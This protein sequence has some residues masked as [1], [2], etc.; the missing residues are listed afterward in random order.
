MNFKILNSAK[1]FF[2]ENKTQHQTIFKNAAWLMA[3]EL[4]VKIIS[5]FALIWLARYLGPNNYGKIAFATNFVAIF[6]F[7]VDFGF[8]T[9]A[10][11]E[12]AKDKSKIPQYIDNILFLQIILGILTF[13]LIFIS[14]IFVSNDKEVLYL[15]YLLGFSGIL[16]IFI[17]F[18]QS[19]F[20]ATEKMEYT[21]LSKVIQ[22]VVLSFIIIFLILQKSSVL[23]IGYAYLVSSLLSIIITVALIWKKITKFFLK[24]DLNFCKKI[25]IEAWPLAILY[26]TLLIFQ[27]FDSIIIGFTRSNEEV[28]LYGAGLRIILSTSLLLSILYSVFLPPISNAFHNKAEGLKSIVEKYAFL[29][30]GLGL[31]LSI[32]GFIVAP[33]LVYFLYGKQYM[34][35]I[36]PFQILSLGLIFVFMVNYYGYCLIF[37]NKQKEV[38]KANLIGVIINV[39]LDLIVI[40]NCGIIGAAVVSIITQLCIL[41]FLFINFEKIIKIN[42]KYVMLPAIFSSFFMA[43]ILFLIK[44]KFDFNVLVLIF[45]GILVYF[46]ACYIF[47][48]Y[49]KKAIKLF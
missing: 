16:D 29:A 49:N 35:A 38:L 10:A 20:C 42:N 11:R 24:I 23:S 31:P 26:L 2:F 33:E 6:S 27:S 7:I 36:I 39:I 34:E 13:G 9:L 17:L 8:P 28:G 25:L 3:A 37:F 18:F 1:S 21:A 43:A 30:F 5:F 48:Y 15:I 32:G 14:S 4:V 45:V 40:P 19:V 22:G 12:M 44:L 46:L 41:I 47:M